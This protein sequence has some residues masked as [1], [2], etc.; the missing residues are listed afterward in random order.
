MLAGLEYAYNRNHRKSESH[1]P[2][3]IWCINSNLLE[4]IKVHLSVDFFDYLNFA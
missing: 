1:F 2:T 4:K 3:Q